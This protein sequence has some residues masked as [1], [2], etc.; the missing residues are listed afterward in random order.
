MCF[1]DGCSV[2]GIRGLCHVDVDTGDRW[3][4]EGILAV[5]RVRVYYLYMGVNE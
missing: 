2:E 5:D 4:S 1:S 3:R